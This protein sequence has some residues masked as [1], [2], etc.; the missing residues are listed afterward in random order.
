MAL[1]KHCSYLT[2]S[3]DAA[4]DAEHK[5]TEPRHLRCTGCGHEVVSE[6][7]NKLPPQNHHTHSS[8]T[9]VCWKLLVYSQAK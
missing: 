6:A 3:A 4:F 5:P 8:G 7:V 9:S 2:I 1:Y